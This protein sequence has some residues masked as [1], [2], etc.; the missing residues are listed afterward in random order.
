MN[1]LNT[2]K[3]SQD[4]LDSARLTIPELRVELLHQLYYKL[5]IPTV[6]WEELNAEGKRWPGCDEVANANWFLLE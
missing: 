5:Q 2:L 1:T 4:I 6:V 3:I